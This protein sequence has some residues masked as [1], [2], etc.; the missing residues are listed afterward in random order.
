MR[1]RHL[2]RIIAGMLPILLLAGAGMLI[3]AVILWVADRRPSRAT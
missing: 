1:A 3:P 2:P